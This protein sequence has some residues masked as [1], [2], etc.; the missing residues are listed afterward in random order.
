[1]K[2]SDL[3]LVGIALFGGYFILK[4]GIVL[5]NSIQNTLKQGSKTAEDIQDAP[6]VIAENAK[7]AVKELVDNTYAAGT[8]LY[9]QAMGS[10]KQNVTQGYINVKNDYFPDVSYSNNLDPTT[11]SIFNLD[12][13]R[14]FFPNGL[15]S[16]GGGGGGAR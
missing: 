9:N 7:K 10:V 3:I 15:I 2:D 6:T 4:E 12:A 5:T 16:D 8:T 14:A 11:K 13:Y 1:M